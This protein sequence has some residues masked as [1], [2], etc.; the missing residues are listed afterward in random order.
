MSEKKSQLQSLLS[1]SSSS[2][3]NLFSSSNKQFLIDEEKCNEYIRKIEQV[4]SSKTNNAC[5]SINTLFP[6]PT[7]SV[8]TDP[9]SK[10][11]MRHSTIKRTSQNNVS[12]NSSCVDIFTKPSPASN[13]G[14]QYDNTSNN[15]NWYSNNS[16]NS[17]NSTME[18][19]D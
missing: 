5:E 11:M 13:C 14:T 19:V 2:N 9:Y 7:L 10:W 17:N 15:G 18:E 4:I 12:K 1:S 8:N 3:K 6:S 16:N